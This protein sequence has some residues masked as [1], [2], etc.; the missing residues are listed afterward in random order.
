MTSAQ[1]I[2]AT[3]LPELERVI[4]DGLRTFVE[5]GR[6]LAKIRDGKLY[7]GE[8]FKSFEAY[9][10][11]RWEM[12][13]PR[14]YSLIEAATVTENVSHARQIPPPANP[15]QASELAKLK[16]PDEQAAAWQEAVAT[17]PEGKVTAKHVAAVVAKIK[18]EEEPASKVTPTDV[19]RA[20]DALKRF[21]PP[22]QVTTEP[23]EEPRPRAEMWWTCPACKT[24]FNAERSLEFGWTSRG[25][26]GHCEGDPEPATGDDE[27]IEVEGE[28]V[29]AVSAHE[30]PVDITKGLDA[31]RAQRMA[32]PEFSRWLAMQTELQKKL[33]SRPMRMALFALQGG[34]VALLRLGLDWSV[35]PETLKQAYREAVRMGHPD[36]G[37][38]HEGFVMLQ[39]YRD[40]I[41]EMLGDGE[42]VA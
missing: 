6:A 29:E 7:Q 31:L 39:R 35:T 28:E 10:R 37:G 5:V 15:R 16:D 30:A 36:R 13:R 33:P 8:G 24:E 19:A 14:A 17:A 18:G 11:E 12:S 22:E 42:R 32:D 38:S 27:P 40:Q 25:F 9:C 21:D 26:C 41:A 34:E 1:A 23:P 2:E 4:A 3:E 20:R